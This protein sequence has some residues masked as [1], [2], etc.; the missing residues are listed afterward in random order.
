MRTFAINAH[1]SLHMRR[2]LLVLVLALS[3]TLNGAQETHEFTQGCI[4]SLPLVLDNATLYRQAH[5]SM[6]QSVSGWNYSQDLSTANGTHTK[7]VLVSYSARAEALYDFPMEVTRSICLVD[8]VVVESGRLN[9]LPLLYVKYTSR[10]EV[11][12]NEMRFTTQVEYGVPWFFFDLLNH[13]MQAGIQAK[14]RQSFAAWYEIIC[15][16][17]P[18]AIRISESSKPFPEAAYGISAGDLLNVLFLP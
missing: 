10:N 4:A 8:E 18:G 16:Q 17:T 11:G 13:W 3:M 12:A 5:M 15:S 2:G 9:L 14:L 7:C 6:N 1:G